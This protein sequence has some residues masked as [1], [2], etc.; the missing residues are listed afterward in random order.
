MA[1][2]RSGAARPNGVSQTKVCQFRL[3]LLG[4]IAVGKSS[5]VLRFV[6]GHFTEYQ[7]S[8]IGAA[9]L[10]QTVSLDN[11]T[12]K[13]EIW[14]TAGQEMYHS[15][16]PM[17]YRGAQAAIVV[18]DITNQDSFR[19]ARNWVKE[20]KQQAAPSIVI[21]LAGNKS[22]LVANNSHLRMV[23]V[24]EAEAYADENRLLFM[25]TSAKT[26]M[27][28]NDI[29]LAIAN[30]LPKSEGGGAGTAGGARRLYDGEQPRNHC[31][32]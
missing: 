16:A 8:T 24:E 7:A 12:V 9:F 20:L 10:T 22:D 3:V 32:K 15:L 13:F 25:E 28:V 30:K 14:D 29:F 27:N 2:N 31:C 18:Y 5:L 26:A 23:E 4:E 11:T 17:Y 1:T 21:A 6:K 19:R